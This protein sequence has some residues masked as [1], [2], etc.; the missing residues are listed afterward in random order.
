M[1][2]ERIP[3][4]SNGPRRKEIVAIGR[5]EKQ[6]NF[7]L[8]IDAFALFQKAHSDYVLTIYGQ[9]SLKEELERY[10]KHNLLFNTYA[11]PG[12]KANVLE[13]ISNAA[14]F[15]LSSDYEG[16]PNVLIEAMALGLPVIATDCPVGGPRELITNGING[17]LVPV[18][19]KKVLFE[20]MCAL[21]DDIF[22][23]E[24][25]GN[26]ALK[27]RGKL[28]INKIANQ[29]LD[30]LKNVCRKFNKCKNNSI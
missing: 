15:V 30:Y 26:N 16:M 5:L 28:E 14:M 17:L 19:D 25:L 12:E 6:K 2:L 21:A 10:A 27:V 11:F 29:W 8:L 22:Y 20:S 23:A 3:K 24:K 1:N 9:G 4:A 7:H 18:G 13:L